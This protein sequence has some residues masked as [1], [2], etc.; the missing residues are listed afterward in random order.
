MVKQS[1]GPKWRGEPSLLFVEG[2]SDLGFYAEL[3]EHLGFE[4]NDYFIQMVGGHDRELLLPELKLT[5]RPDRLERLCSVAVLFDS[6]G[7]AQEAFRSARDAISRALGEFGI[8][9][10]PVPAPEVWHPVGVGNTKFGVF[11]A[12]AKSGQQEIE[13]MAWNAWRADP[14]M[15]G[16]KKCVEEFKAQSEAAGW[17]WK[18]PDK[19]RIG[20]TLAVVHEDDPRLGPAARAKWFDFDHPEFVGLCRFLN[21]MK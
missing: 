17:K 6:D 21:G 11:V 9:V 18:S 8:E 2:Y 12:G 13:S 7:Q 19:G 16:L 3:L 14:R 5:L 4:R 1:A 20:A 10:P 15:P